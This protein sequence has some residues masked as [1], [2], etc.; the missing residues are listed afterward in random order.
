MK[1]TIFFVL[2]GNNGA[3]YICNANNWAT[4][5]HSLKFY[6]ART[7]K[8]KFLKFGLQVLLF[9]KGKLGVPALKTST[10]VET[11]I[12]TIVKNKVG[13]NI[14]TACSIL[15]SPTQDKVIVNHHNNYFEKFAFG[16]SYTK[17]KKEAAIYNLF[18]SAQKH[19][20]VS[21]IYDANFVDNNYCLFKLS[22]KN[23]LTANATKEIALVPILIEFF[24]ISKRA[25]TTI[26]IYSNQLQQSIKALESSAYTPQL[27]LLEAFK[28]EFETRVFP[29]GLVHK[30]FKPWNV[31]PYDK[32]LIYDF[33]ETIVN[34]LPLEDLLNYYIDPII[35][36]KSTTEVL[37]SIKTI[38]SLLKTYLK[39]LEITIDHTVFLQ[40]Y[41]MERLIFYSTENDKS[42]SNKYKDL[43]NLIIKE[44]I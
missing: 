21:R 2:K 11:Y 26:T 20:Q 18:G 36:F 10:D 38:K 4:L 3:T 24:N 5:N 34:G 17:I 32:I 41:C 37:G 33:E 35:R 19:F 14:D 28:N 29:L 39:E 43:S 12:Q 13:F 22:N 9:L 15:I 7:A 30:D 44:R 40:F 16:K 8:A 23:V 6:K 27:E 31:L 1:D 25:T 42:T